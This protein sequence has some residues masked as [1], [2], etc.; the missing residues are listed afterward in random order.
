MG[1]WTALYQTRMY[2]SEGDGMEVVFMFDSEAA[3][4]LRQRTFKAET[5]QIRDLVDKSGGSLEPLH[6]DS[7]DPN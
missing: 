7:D 3:R 4:T 1:I 2:C 6:P 5:E